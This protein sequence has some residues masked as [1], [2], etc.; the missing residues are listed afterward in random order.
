MASHHNL[1]LGVG[2]GRVERRWRREALAGS[3]LASLVFGRS[4]LRIGAFTLDQILT[5]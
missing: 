2:P 3:Q 5:A 1:E 4:L